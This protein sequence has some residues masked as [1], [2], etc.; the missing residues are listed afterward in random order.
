MK[1][2][3]LS[4][5]VGANGPKAFWGVHPSFPSPNGSIVPS[6]ALKDLGRPLACGPSQWLS[7]SPKWGRLPELS[8]S[9]SATTLD[10]DSGSG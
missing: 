9:L 2:A 10:P 1:G 7:G 6:L 8:E 3:L 4:Y 5:V